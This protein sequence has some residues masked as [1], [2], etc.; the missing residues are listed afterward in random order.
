MYTYVKPNNTL[1]DHSNSSTAYFGKIAEKIEA[2][3]KVNII[4]IGDF[5]RF[6]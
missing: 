3:A 6:Y 5:A 4:A 1:T 2:E